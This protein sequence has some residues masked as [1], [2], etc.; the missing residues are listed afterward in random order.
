M[1]YFIKVYS[2]TLINKN[3]QSDFKA[4]DIYSPIDYSKILDKFPF[5]KSINTISQNNI[6][7]HSAI[8]ETRDI[9]LAYN[10]REN[11][12]LNML[13]LNILEKK[14]VKKKIIDIFNFMIKDLFQSM[15]YI[16]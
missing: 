4:I 15:F 11:P 12:V 8:S 7:E 14:L 1:K 5:R 6:I 9:I 10:L 3:I 13:I 16:Y 2:L